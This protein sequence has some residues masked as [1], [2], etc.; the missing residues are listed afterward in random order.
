MDKSDMAFLLSDLLFSARRMAFL[1]GVSI[2]E[3]LIAI[4]IATMSEFYSL[5]PKEKKNQEDFRKFLMGRGEIIASRYDGEFYEIIRRLDER[6]GK[7][8]RLAD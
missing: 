5:L 3:F 2:D 1:A 4:D 8:G 6:R 7:N